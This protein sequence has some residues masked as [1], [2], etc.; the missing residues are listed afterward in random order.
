MKR[1]EFK[2]QD[3]QAE[4]WIYDVIGKD[5]WGEGISAKA[6]AEDLEAL[7]EVDRLTVRINSP[8]GSVF[9]G[10][11]IFNTLRRFGA[12]IV[13]SVDGVAASA[14]SLVAMAG[15]R[16][17]MA[18][19]A[20]MMIHQ[21]YAYADGTAEE[22]RKLADVLDKTS[23]NLITAYA[24]QA[25]TSREKVKDW[26]DAE[27][28]F[29][30]AEAVDVGLADEITGALKLAACIPAGVYRKTPKGLEITPQEAWDQAYEAGV[31]AGSDFM[32]RVREMAKTGS[33]AAPQRSAAEKLLTLIGP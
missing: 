32:D 24:N 6:F 3:R 27:T 1:A 29:T 22:H 33:G 25:A 2:C 5:F 11:T 23:E 20:M 8:G 13:V 17:T 14:A 26:L 28:W 10:N 18:E 31:K 19:N 15:D 30:A 9:D 7:G 16:I 12:E 21:P 4:V